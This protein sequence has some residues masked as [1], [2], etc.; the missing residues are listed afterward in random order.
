MI[1]FYWWKV[2]EFCVELASN[3]I[4]DAER[5]KIFV[6]KW[7][8]SPLTSVEAA[9][10]CNGNVSGRQGHQ[11]QDPLDVDNLHFSDVSSV[12]ILG[13]APHHPTPVAQYSNQ[14]FRIICIFEF[15]GFRVNTLP[16]LLFFPNLVSMLC[17]KWI[18]Q[19]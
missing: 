5:C 2:Y 10:W 1:F 6:A 16:D 19:N 3:L 15:I 14:L 13:P 17:I 7:N 9:G 4:V 18:H 11:G 8:N 12:V